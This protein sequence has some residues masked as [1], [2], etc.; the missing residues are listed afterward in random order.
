MLSFHLI[1]GV[2]LGYILCNVSL[3]TISPK[4]FFHI[5]I[6]LGIPRVNRIW[7]FVSFL[8]NQLSQI[9]IL[10]YTNTLSEPDGSLLIFTKICGL[11]FSQGFLQSLSDFHYPFVSFLSFSNSI[12]QQWLYYQRG[13]K[14][15]RHNFQTEISECFTQVLG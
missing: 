2:T 1:A 6:H 13:N 9:S 8:Q 14:T 15:F 5:H 7:G 11:A 12:H 10:W 3:Q 4:S